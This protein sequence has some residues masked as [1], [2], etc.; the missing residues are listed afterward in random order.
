MCGSK[1]RRYRDRLRDWCASMSREDT[2]AIVGPRKHAR[3]MRKT[4]NVRDGE[5]S[6]L[7][8]AIRCPYVVATY[9]TR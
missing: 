4:P 2:G 7:A 9:R 3:K 1:V 6:C 8:T 5:S